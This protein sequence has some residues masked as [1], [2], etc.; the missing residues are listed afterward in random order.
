MERGLAL[1]L[2]A[3]WRH[4]EANVGYSKHLILFWYLPQCLAR[5]GSH[6]QVEYKLGVI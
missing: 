4:S 5:L 6:H 2:I 3:K 1:M